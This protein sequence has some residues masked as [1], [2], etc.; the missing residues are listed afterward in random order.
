MTTNNYNWSSNNLLNQYSDLV[1]TGLV[2]ICTT[3]S[4]NKIYLLDNSGYLLI[5][6]TGGSNTIGDFTYSYSQVVSNSASQHFIPVNQICCDASGTYILLE[7][8][9]GSHYN[10]YYSSNSGSTFSTISISSNTYATVY[11]SGNGKN[12]AIIAIST[13]YLSTNF[14]TSFSQLTQSASICAFSYT[15]DFLYIGYNTDLYIYDILSSS[16]ILIH[17]DLPYDI[18]ACNPYIDTSGQYFT[19]LLQ[20]PTDDI[21]YSTNNYLSMLSYTNIINGLYDIQINST[22]NSFGEYLI[23][24]LGNQTVSTTISGFNN[25]IQETYFNTTGQITCV[26][27]NYCD[28]ANSPVAMCIG[29]ITFDTIG[30]SDVFMFYYG[31]ITPINS[32]NSTNSSL[33]K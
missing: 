4:G 5:I 23:I 25:F 17:I 27:T 3:S 21:L 13:L 32:S 28:N 30:P 1:L 29:N 7:L 33:V 9:T 2:G 24:S 31:Y 11:I 14:G 26:A 10:F 22:N 6:N 8:Y 16:Y 18:P 15:G 12:M 19:F 20:S